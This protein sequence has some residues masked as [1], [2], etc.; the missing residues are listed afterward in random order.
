MWVSIRDKLET[1]K[2]EHIGFFKTVQTDF[3]AVTCQCFFGCRLA[4]PHPHQSYLS[5]SFSLCEPAS[6]S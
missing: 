4:C 5:L 2:V 3:V 6:G 1:R